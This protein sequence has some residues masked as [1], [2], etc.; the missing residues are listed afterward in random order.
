MET[1]GVRRIFFHRWCFKFGCRPWCRASPEKKSL[2]V[3]GEGRGV[4]GGTPTLGFLPLKG[5]VT[6]PGKRGRGNYRTLPTSLTSK[7]ATTIKTEPKGGV[8][9]CTPVTPPRT[10]PLTTLNVFRWVIIVV[11]WKWR[12]WGGKLTL[13]SNLKYPRSIL[14]PSEIFVWCHPAVSAALPSQAC[15]VCS[16]FQVCA[17]S[18]SLS[19]APHPLHSSVFPLEDLW[20]SC[21]VLDLFHCLSFGSNIPPKVH[22]VFVPSHK[23][24]THLLQRLYVSFLLYFLKHQHHKIL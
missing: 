23:Y 1:R 7:R 11:L 19:W 8:G 14:P 3:V 13:M 4:W 9:V 15:I 22:L 2:G 6:F 16:V 10:R 5:C 18:S 24:L 12:R 17:A 20:D 21:L